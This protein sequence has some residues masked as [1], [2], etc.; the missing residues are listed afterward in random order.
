[1]FESAAIRVPVMTF[2]RAGFPP[3]PHLEFYL[4]IKMQIMLL[5]MYFYSKIIII[6]ITRQ[7]Y[8]AQSY[9]STDYAQ[10]KEHTQQ[11][12]YTMTNAIYQELRTL[13]IMR[14]GN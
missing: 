9:Y 12:I 4:E 13:Q 7:I 14:I 11:L 2:W 10:I 5:K 1:M 6:I 3:K 8:L